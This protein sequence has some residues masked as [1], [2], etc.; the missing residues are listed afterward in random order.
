MT[1]PTKNIN[2][3]YGIVMGSPWNSRLQ[4]I[5]LAGGTAVLGN[6]PRAVVWAV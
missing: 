6:H 2:Q 1:D 5:A 4:L 3:R